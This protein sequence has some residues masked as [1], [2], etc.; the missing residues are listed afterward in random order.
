MVRTLG[1]NGMVPGPL[2]RV[3]EGKTVTV[4]V[5]ND[6]DVPELVHWHGLHIASEA[7][8]SME[9][10]TPMVAPHASRR[11]CFPATPSGGT[12]WYHTHTMAGRN[13]K[14]GTY[15]GQ[16]GFFYIEPRNEA[17]GYDREVF[18]ALKEWDPYLST[19]G[20]DSG[21]EVAYKYGR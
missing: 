16:F 8:G 15:T 12:R 5:F 18:L 13:L 11:Y 2:L 1:Y 9:E 6:T 4:E 10:G 7:D 3:P 19:M 14:R 17:G 20:E 21:L